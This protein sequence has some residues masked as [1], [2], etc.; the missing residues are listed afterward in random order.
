[1]FVYILIL[2][3]FRITWFTWNILVTQQNTQSY[4]GVHY[5]A[6]LCFLNK[7]PPYLHSFSCILLTCY[8]LLIAFSNPNLHYSHLSFYVLEGSFVVSVL[9]FSKQF[10]MKIPVSFD[11]SRLIT[12]SDSYEMY[13]SLYYL[14][15]NNSLQNLLNS[16]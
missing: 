14:K 13:F 10:L 2:F 4:N 12:I 5:H 16:N 11:L 7:L 3:N 9:W 1:M 6:M 8:L 15:G